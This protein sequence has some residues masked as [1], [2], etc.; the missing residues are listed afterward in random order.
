MLEMFDHSGLFFFFAS[1][2]FDLAIVCLVGSTWLATYAAILASILTASG[3][4]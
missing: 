3:V 2:A 1:S 4:R